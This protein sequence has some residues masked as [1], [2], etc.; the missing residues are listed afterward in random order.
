M[1]YRTD[2]FG[3]L[4]CTIVDAFTRTGHPRLAVILAHGYGAPGDDLVPLAAHLLHDEDVREGVRFVFPHGPIALRHIPG[5]RAWWDLDV[6]QL[7]AAVETG[8][9]DDF[10][11]HVPQHLPL[12][13]SCFDDFVRALGTAWRLRPQQLVV[14][15]FSQ[16]SMLATDWALHAEENVAGLCI[17]SGTLLCEEEWGR[18]ARRH[19]GLAVFQSHGRFDPLL[20]FD[21]AVR[22]RDLLQAAGLAVDFL[23][24]DGEHTIPEAAV[25]GL[26]RL[27]R[28]A[29]EQDV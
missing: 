14:G 15:G 24:F 28:A 6:E 7:I 20:P 13:R 2:R 12:A 16:G 10:R 19:A 23:A 29:L 25:D 5:G 9:F 11:Q 18:W 1:Q 22:L 3:P 27:I 17:W 4:D 21:A 8:T 26:L